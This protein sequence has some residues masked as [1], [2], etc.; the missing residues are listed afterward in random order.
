M[1]N[2]RPTTNCQL[3]VDLMRRAMEASEAR[4]DKI[5][6]AMGIGMAPMTD[7]QRYD[8]SRSSGMVS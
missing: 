2:Q 4:K 8:G 7:T 3:Q 1:L 6:K 5:D